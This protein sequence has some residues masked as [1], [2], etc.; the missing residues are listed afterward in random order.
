M[1]Q[2]NDL[3]KESKD[4]VD[5]L[6]K[7]LDN[8][9]FNCKNINNFMNLLYKEYPKSF[10]TK[11]VN[12]GHLSNDILKLLRLKD[13]EI[14]L[15]DKNN[16]PI[17]LEE[18][19]HIFNIPQIEF[20]NILIPVNDHMHLN[21][22]MRP[23]K[24]GDRYDNYFTMYC[25][26]KTLQPYFDNWKFKKPLKKFN[27][28]YDFKLAKKDFKSFERIIKSYLKKIGNIY[29]NIKRLV[30]LKEWLINEGFIK[31]NVP[32]YHTKN[33]TYIYVKPLPKYDNYISIKSICVECNDNTGLFLFH[34]FKN[35]KF[36]NVIYYFRL[37]FL[38]IFK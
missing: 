32:I 11:H 13:S 19:K 17:K 9:L 14:E 28:S 2:Y 3:C 34:H 25:T 8:F 36:E 27:Y 30:E 33:S 6:Q 21:I 38:H 20:S 15:C 1:I 24:V 18:I 10:I 37:L 31:N 26:V 22:I 5:Y 35:I 4:Y 12:N 29:K 23:N 16:K 7:K